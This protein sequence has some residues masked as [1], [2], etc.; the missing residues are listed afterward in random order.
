MT[1]NILAFS[2]SSFA[3]I[4]KRAKNR[5]HI[6]MRL[7]NNTPNDRLGRI[8]LGYPIKGTEERNGKRTDPGC[9]QGV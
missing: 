8:I 2:R 7:K 9:T 6:C 5:Y 4:E 1:K 3:V